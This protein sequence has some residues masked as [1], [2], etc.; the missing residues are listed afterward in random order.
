[1]RPKGLGKLNKFTLSGIEPATFRL[2]G[3]CLNQYATA[4]VQ[5]L[6]THDTILKTAERS[7]TAFHPSEKKSCRGPCIT[8]YFGAGNQMDCLQLK[9][10][11]IT[12]RFKTVLFIYF[13]VFPRLSLLPDDIRM[14]ILHY[15]CLTALKV[16]SPAYINRPC[17]LCSNRYTS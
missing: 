1:V 15:N 9:G 14:P 11:P 10:L 16:D 3:Q 8:F 6:V 12:E 5:L 2:V 4:Y 7:V 17:T 13:L